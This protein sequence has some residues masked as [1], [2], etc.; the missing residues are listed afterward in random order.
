MNNFPFLDEIRKTYQLCPRVKEEHIK[1]FEKVLL[2]LLNYDPCLVKTFRAREFFSFDPEREYELEAA[3]ITLRM[4]EWQSVE[5]LEKIIQGTINRY[6]SETKESA[7]I[8]KKAARE[9][10]NAWKELK[11]EHPEVF[12]DELTLPVTGSLG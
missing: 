11:G 8:F 3:I 5:A 7:V 12:P 10:W 4:K 9:I 2:I 6:F 1:I